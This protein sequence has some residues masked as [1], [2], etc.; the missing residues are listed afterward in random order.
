MISKDHTHT[1]QP[2]EALLWQID[3]KYIFI[4]GKYLFW[5][6]IS[7]SQ[8]QLLLPNVVSNYIKRFVDIQRL[9]IAYTCQPTESLCDKYN[10]RDVISWWICVFDQGW[11]TKLANTTHFWIRRAQPPL[12]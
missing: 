12:P 8:V 10:L 3:I 4:L 1:F 2:T 5:W 9:N 7:L 6:N 11:K